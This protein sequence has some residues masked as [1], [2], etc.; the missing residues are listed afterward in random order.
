[1]KNVYPLKVLADAVP[2]VDQQYEIASKVLAKGLV[3]ILMPEVDELRLCSVRS[4]ASFSLRRVCR[5]DSSK[6]K[7]I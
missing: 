3:P 4:G 2:A 5:L 6:K 1:M 7:F